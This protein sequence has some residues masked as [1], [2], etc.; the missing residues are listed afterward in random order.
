MIKTL[1]KQKIA[2][3]LG[4]VL[5]LLVMACFLNAKSTALLDSD[6]SSEMVLG[7]LL[8]R[9]GTLLTDQWYYSTEIRVL[10]TQILSAFFFR[11]LH[12]WHAV[13]MAVT[14]SLWLI[15]LASYRFLC[16]ALECRPFFALTAALLLLPFSKEYLQYVLVGGY[17]IPHIAI[18]FATL[19][20]NAQ[21]RKA[22][23]RGR[24]LLLAVSMLLAF[25]GGMG[26][27]RLILNLY[28]PL[29]LTAAAGLL[30]RRDP[31]R[32]KQF[33]YAVMTSAV[34]SLSGYAV[35]L[36]YL[37][38]RYHFSHMEQLHLQ[39][40]DPVRA[41]WVLCDLFKAF[42]CGD[43]ASLPGIV[44]HSAMSFV[45]VAAVLLC[46]RRAFTRPGSAAYHLAAMMIVSFVCYGLVILFTDMAVSARYELPFAVLS[47]P[48][49]AV[50]ASEAKQE[51]CRRWLKGVL[52]AMGVMAL[53]LLWETMPVDN[54]AELRRVTA[55]LEAEGY[56]NGYATF[57]NA[58]V[59]TELSD[60]QIEVWCWCEPYDSGLMKHSTDV[61]EVYEW[62]QPVCHETRRPSGKVFVLLASDEM[63]ENPWKENLSRDD[64]LY[65]S[66][67]YTVLGY[68][69]YET[70]KETL[71]RG[72]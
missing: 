40:P 10:N 37:Q 4:L 62:L 5:V 7:S 53:L 18:I 20:L 32:R 55:Q 64:V 66:E 39:A 11:I 63:R 72:L 35:N 28:L 1:Q 58:N 52:G 49:L 34:G 41:W 9:S 45:W 8:A 26:G 21:Y 65:E 30:D 25:F 36:F 59:L 24:W 57:W 71:G 22:S 29:G 27:P 42:G 31:Q 47:F 6:M 19:A 38:R 2:E 69:D 15:L 12:S 56:Q 16:R 48:L 50:T 60:G 3:R 61:D 43:G 54:T 44:L 70:L 68:P 46:I 51:K 67:E 14:I 33:F 23:G 13:R 17:Y